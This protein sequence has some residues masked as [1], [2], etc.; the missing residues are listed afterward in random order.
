MQAESR[1]SAL[2]CW[3]GS[4]PGTSLLTDNTKYAVVAYETS[5]RT[6]EF[7]V[8]VALGA[9]RGAVIRRA[10]GRSLL[11]SAAGAALGLLGAVALTRL[12]APVLNATTATNSA[13]FAA[14]AAFLLAAGAAGASLP[15][16]RAARADPM[17][18]LRAEK[19]PAP[20]DARGSGRIEPHAGELPL[21]RRHR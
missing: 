17:A 8:R 10:L 9:T 15:A 16:R 19:G 2:S 18:E 13:T 11:H 12:L 4:V 3:R 5:A 7:G 14:A 1:S 6:Q 21:R 20:R